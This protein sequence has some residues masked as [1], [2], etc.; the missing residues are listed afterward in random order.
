MK[1]QFTLVAIM[2][3]CCVYLQGQVGIGTDTPNPK[4]ILDLNVSSYSGS[5]KKGLLIP[6]MTDAQRNAI[7][8][9][10]AGLA[11]YSL[12]DLSIHTYDG[13]RWFKET[14]NT[15]NTNYQ[16]Y[17]YGDINTPV[18]T[19]GQ[20][21]Q[22]WTLSLEYASNDG[23]YAEDV[24]GTGA[25]KI[26]TTGTY[27]IEFYGRALKTG[28]VLPGAVRYV[29]RKNGSNFFT[30]ED[31]YGDSPNNIPNGGTV[32]GIIPPVTLNAGDLLTLWCG[33]KN[34]GAGFSYNFSQ[35]IITITKIGN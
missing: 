29:I 12:D 35:N 27:V 1:I 15:Y 9:P 24:P 20:L 19:A 17:R 26:L 5:D 33:D 6:R 13:V 30:F 25:I 2:L 7:A 14:R 31:S 8:S 34:G 3:F 23:D 28:V 22:I 18:N 21:F 32:S 11:I 4:A 16:Y 10:A